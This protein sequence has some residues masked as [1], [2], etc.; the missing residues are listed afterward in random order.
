MGYTTLAF[1]VEVMALSN[2]F[3]KTDEN[4]CVRDNAG[5]TFGEYLGKD[6]YAKVRT[7]TKQQLR[8]PNSGGISKRNSRS[9]IEKRASRNSQMDLPQR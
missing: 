7:T 4:G 1:V 9:T 5:D 6:G 3:L 2:Y 8:S